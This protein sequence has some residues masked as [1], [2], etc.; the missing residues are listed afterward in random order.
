MNYLYKKIDICFIY[1][2]EEMVN[3]KHILPAVI[4]VFYVQVPSA[5][6]LVSD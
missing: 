3:R 5:F 4:S 1:A 6:A 2:H